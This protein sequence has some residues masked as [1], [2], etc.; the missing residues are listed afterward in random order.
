MKYDAYP[1][2][3]ARIKKYVSDNGMTLEAFADDL[4]MSR[5]SL[6]NKHE[7]KTPLGFEEARKIADYLRI[8]LND[9]S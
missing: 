2:T 9:Y 8:S 4:G 6:Q 5:Q 7:G 1:N 3:Y